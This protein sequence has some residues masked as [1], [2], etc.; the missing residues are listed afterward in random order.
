MTVTLNLPDGM[1]TRLRQEAQVRGMT[2]E[3]YLVSVIEFALPLQAQ[4]VAAVAL[5][6]VLDAFMH[7]TEGQQQEA[8]AYLQRLK[9]EEGGA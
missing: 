4:T 2:L 6:Q 7:G 5:Q 1:E 9:D 8:L 3:H